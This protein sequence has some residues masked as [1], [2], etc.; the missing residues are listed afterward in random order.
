MK[1]IILNSVQLASS[2]KLDA[3]YCAKKQLK[4][5]LLGFIAVILIFISCTEQPKKHISIEDKNPSQVEETESDESQLT[6]RK[7]TDLS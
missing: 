6:G 5:G 4:K 2:F 3:S 7:I 1:N